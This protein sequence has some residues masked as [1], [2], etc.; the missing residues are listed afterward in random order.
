L[1]DV[2]AQSLWPDPDGR[3][4]VSS[5]LGLGYFRDAQFVAVDGLL[6]KEVYSMAGD[7]KGDLW[8]SGNTGLSRFHDGRFVENFP[9]AALGRWQQAKVVV[10]D[11]GG[12]WLS[13]WQDGG[14]LFFKDGKVRVAYTPAEGLGRGHVSGLRRDD[15]G[16]LWAST[17][18]GGLSRIKDGHIQTLT[19][20]NGL[21]CDTIHWSIVDHNGSLWM[22]TACG[23][24]RI[25]RDDVDAWVADPAKSVHVNAWGSADGVTPRAVSPNYFN[26][27]VA[28]A[29]DGK[30]W[31]VA[32]EG[33]QIVDPDHLPSNAIPPPVY[34][35]RFVAD[36]KYYPATPELSLPPLVRDITIEF[37]AL[38]LADPANVHFRYRL[39]GH[40]DDWRETTNLRQASY[41]NLRP[42]TYRFQVKA[43][44][45]AKASA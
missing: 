26:P 33:V 12:V 22:N 9:W 19:T 35:E 43:S 3:V 10:P 44:S 30:I 7:G 25:L 38:S 14:V 6:S 13:F 41:S 37:T 1:P 36:R 31:F 24:L 29:P 32:G 39:E 27:P 2:G 18:E 17:E 8:L 45:V 23:L 4:W 40:D 42:G 16:A 28:K 11:D 15:D 34:I 20:R 21:P 5:S